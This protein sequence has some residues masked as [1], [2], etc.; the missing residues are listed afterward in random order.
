MSIYHCPFCSSRYQFHKCRNDG[1][2][3]CGLCGDP[4]VKKP[5]ISSRRIIGLV[6]A[7]AFLSPLLIMVIF[8]VKN[9]T[10][11]K[12]PINSQSLVLSNRNKSW[13]I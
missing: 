12:Q 5:L 2:L 13:K 4:L 11:E 6:V 9:F 3:I 1:V 8:I 7:S 10:E